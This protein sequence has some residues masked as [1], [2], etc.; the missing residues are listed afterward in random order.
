MGCFHQ[1]GKVWYICSNGIFRVLSVTITNLILEATSNNY[2]LMDVYPSICN[3]A[4]NKLLENPIYLRIDENNGNIIGQICFTD[5]GPQF[6]ECF[7]GWCFFIF[8]KDGEKKMY[9]V[10]DKQ[11][12]RKNNDKLLNEKQSIR[13]TFKNFNSMLFIE[14][15][16]Y[17]EL[18]IAAETTLFLTFKKNGEF[19][20][21]VVNDYK[22][23]ELIYFGDFLDLNNLDLINIKTRIVKTVFNYQE[24]KYHKYRFN[25][26][27][28]FLCLEL[29]D[30]NSQKS[31]TGTTIYS[32][33][34]YCLHYK[35]YIK[36]NNGYEITE[37]EYLHFARLNP[38][39]KT[40]GFKQVQEKLT[41]LGFI[42]ATCQMRDFVTISIIKL[43]I[44]NLESYEDPWYLRRILNK[45]KTK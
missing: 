39:K 9:W 10:L 22:V 23:K 35:D 45:I 18:C 6:Y 41:F 38:S 8:R 4:Q 7:K 2:I 20:N 13:L 25:Y 11:W 28:R 30:L 42:S 40:F 17:F 36:G 33:V 32:K 15:D 3:R 27:Q 37:K 31:D 12:M 5:E 1:T 19:L 24:E 43:K 14:K 16:E 21:L 34:H 44:F 29:H 26:N